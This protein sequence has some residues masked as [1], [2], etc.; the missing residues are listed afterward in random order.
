M[1]HYFVCLVFLL[2]G[3]AALGQ[4]NGILRTCTK[5]SM[6]YG[7][8]ER[9]ERF[10]RQGHCTFRI[11]HDLNY[12]V[13]ES[14]DYDTEGRLIRW[15]RLLEETGACEVEEYEYTPKIVRSYM[16]KSMPDAKTLASI[17]AKDP[18]AKMESRAYYA[19][20]DTKEKFTQKPW[21]IWQL[22][23]PSYLSHITFRNAKGQPWTEYVM[24]KAEDTISSYEYTYDS[25]GRE[26]KRRDLGD[27][28]SQKCED[29]ETS[30]DSKGR[31]AKV[32]Y[33]TWG[34]QVVPPR[35]WTVIYDYNERGQLISEST[36]E[37]GQTTQQTSYCYDVASYQLLT[38]QLKQ[39]PYL[40]KKVTLFENDA[41]GNPIKMIVT[42][43]RAKE[44][45]QKSFQIVNEYWE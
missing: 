3:L 44:S 26:I 27:H 40:S 33:Q 30:Y 20:I 42:E 13:I 22:K 37:N 9:L 38:L 18:D 4:S 35:K 41:Q 43:Y 21:Y 14:M 17:L 28:H 34:Y 36:L 5:L 16:R 10:D 25:L 11:S 23:S 2:L 45:F 39:E 19:A 29:R 24:Q 32:M 7:D 31:P 15:A 6:P 12:L 8:L 1:K